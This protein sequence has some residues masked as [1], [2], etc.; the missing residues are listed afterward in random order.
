M[1][2]ELL[3]AQTIDQG[4]DIILREGERHAIIPLQPVNIMQGQTQPKAKTQNDTRPDEE[5]KG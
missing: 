4:W 5:E 1:N 3:S 2:I